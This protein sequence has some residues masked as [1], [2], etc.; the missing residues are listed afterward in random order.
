M[1]NER[2]S[3]A[4][5]G[6]EGSVEVPQSAGRGVIADH[7]GYHRKSASSAV[8]REAVEVP[9]VPS[10]GTVSRVDRDRVTPVIE[11]E[12]R[13]GSD[14]LGPV[15]AGVRHKREAEFSHDRM[16]HAR[17]KDHAGASRWSRTAAGRPTSSTTDHFTKRRPGIAAPKGIWAS[18]RKTKLSTPAA[19]TV[20]TATGPT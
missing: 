15:A 12:E 10:L 20:E 9:E 19:M 11:G 14:A 3:V 13:E 6:H 18:D 5:L 17:V 2:R 7:I 4:A 16:V 8:L 1:E